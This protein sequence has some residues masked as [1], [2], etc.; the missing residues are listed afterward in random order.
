[1]VWNHI[2]PICKMISTLENHLKCNNKVNLRFLV[3][4]LRT[5]VTL[6]PTLILANLYSQERTLPFV[7]VLTSFSRHEEPNIMVLRYRFK[8]S[9]SFKKIFDVRMK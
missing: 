6:P 3:L 9:I 7:K 2:G 1:M 8:K 4:V 5:T